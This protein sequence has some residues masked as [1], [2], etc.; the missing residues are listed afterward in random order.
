M[1]AALDDVGS[2]SNRVVAR[3]I[4]D[5]LDALARTTLDQLCGASARPTNARW[6]A[7]SLDDVRWNLAFLAQSVSENCPDLFEEYIVWLRA[8]LE[9]FHV[10]RHDVLGW[11]EIVQTH[12]EREL[13]GCDLSTLRECVDRARRVYD[14]ELVTPPPAIDP[15]S[16]YGDLAEGYLRRVL[17]AERADAVSYLLRAVDD[18]LD[19]R[20][21]YLRVLQ[22]VQR[23]IGRRWHLRQVSVAQEHFATAVTQLVLAQLYPRIA[24]TPKTAGT[25]V[26]VSVGGE[27]HELGIR[28]V[29]DFFELAG[30]NSHY[31][32]ANC[33]PAAVADAARRH[34]ADLVA[35]SASIVLRLEVLREVIALV[36]AQSDSATQVLVGGHPFNSSPDLWRRV[37]ADGSAADADGA[38]RVGAALLGLGG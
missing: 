19:I 4:T 12:L 7:A 2:E 14:G 21:L 8:A 3:V 34:R 36:R 16:P 9:P 38:V 5:G 29:A 6:F 22:P 33:P 15:R 37:G 25:I 24:R 23:E 32:G 26:A 31:L 17:A 35:V 10:G 30:W 20:D 11:L 13:P 1:R 28:M 18:G 27:L